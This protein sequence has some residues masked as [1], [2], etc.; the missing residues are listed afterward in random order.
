MGTQHRQRELIMKIRRAEFLLAVAIVTSAAVMQIREYVLNAAPHDAVQTLSC[1]TSHQGLVPAA[2][3][4]VRSE[5]PVDGAARPQ[6]SA[7]RIWV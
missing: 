4:A 7:P 3:A 6:P 1:G 5:H 2:C